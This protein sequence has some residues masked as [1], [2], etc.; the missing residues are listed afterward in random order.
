MS[1]VTLES[2]LRLHL[3]R[4]NIHSPALRLSVR[5]LIGR[6]IRTMRGAA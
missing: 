4:R 2:A 3:Q 6:T 5:A 1:R